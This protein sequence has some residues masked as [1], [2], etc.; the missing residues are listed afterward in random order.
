VESINQR[1]DLTLR[2]SVYFTEHCFAPHHPVLKGIISG[3]REEAPHPVLF[4]VDRG[5][6]DH[7]PELLSAIASYGERNGFRPAASPFL[8]QGGEEA[9]NHPEWV[10]A[11]HRQI[12]QGKLCRHSYVIVVGGGSV[13]DLAGYAAATAHRGIRLV[14]IPTTVLAQADAAIGVKNGVNAFGKKNFLGTFSTPY[15]VINDAAFLTTLS[16]RD[17]RSGIAEA[18]KVALIKDRLFFSFIER[19]ALKLSRRS[20]APMKELIAWSAR[21]HLNH[22]ATGGDPFE[23]GTSRP[24]DFGHWAAHRLEALT[25]F[26]LRHGEAVAI[27]VALD[28]TYSYLSGWLS[29]QAWRRIISL[30]IAI[31]FECTAPELTAGGDENDPNALFMGLTEFR[32]HLGGKLTL[33]MLK[34]IG[35]GMEVYEV[36]LPRM[37]RA[38]DLLKGSTRSLSIDQ[39]E[40]KKKGMKYA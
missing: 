32:E 33:M 35:Q 15:A 28:S 14:R 39:K 7:F 4:V 31:G 9:K 30:L 21:L 26:R 2:Y 19:E 18:I 24:L 16:D 22:I 25:K 5:V 23:L 17:W 8:V 12:D 37:A 6:A 1:V 13:I 20:T 27:G 11:L 10:T 36:D 29:E 40:V 3:G 34:G 38:I